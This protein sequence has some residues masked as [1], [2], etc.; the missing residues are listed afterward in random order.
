MLVLPLVTRYLGNR[1]KSVEHLYSMF[2][3]MHTF[4]V[5]KSTSSLN[6]TNMVVVQKVR[7]SAAAV[8]VA[9][10]AAAAASDAVIAT[11]TTTKD[12]GIHGA[13][14]QQRLS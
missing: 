12:A 8:T 10:A 14:L 3:P 4:H 7:T 1:I 11:A 5:V 9:V 2:R 6:I 13:V